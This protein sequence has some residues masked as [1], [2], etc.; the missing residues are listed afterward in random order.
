M[1]DPTALHE[2]R[3]LEAHAKRLQDV[4]LTSLFDGASSRFDDFS[5][6]AA[7]LFLDWSKNKI[8]REA[9]DGLFALARAAGVEARREAMFAGAP[10]NETEGRSVLHV[11]LRAPRGAGYAI[12][13]ADVSALIE[14]ERDRMQRFC[15]GVHKGAH[16]GFTDKPLTRV[17]NIGIGGSDLG[18][19]MAVEALRPY[20]IEG[21]RADFVSNIDGQHLAD[22][23]HDA[24][25][26]TTLFVIASKTFTTQETLTNARS[27]RDWFLQSGAGEADIAKHFVALSTNL[28]AV[29]AFGIDETNMFR[30]WDW[31]GGRYSLWSAIGLSIALQVGFS[32]FEKLLA[33]AHAMDEHFRS[34]PL[35]KNMPV[36]LAMAGVWNRNFQ[37]IAAHAVL[38]Y[39]QH[40]HRLP[41]Y[42]QQADM[43]SNGKRVRLDGGLSAC[44]TGPVLFG[45]PGTN[46][47]HAFY[48]LLHQGTD[49]VSADFIA[50]A[51]SARELGDHHEKLLANFLAQPEALMRGKSEKEAR[52][53]L[54]GAGLSD[55]EAARLASHKTFPGGR[56]SNAILM[57]R[58]TPETLGALIALYEHKIFVQGAVWGVNSFDQW[59]V[60]L[61]KALA[62]TILPEI[63]R[64]GESKPAPKGHDASTNGLIARVNAI[65]KKAGDAEH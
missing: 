31:V 10:I 50:A 35:E 57:E 42:L 62:K 52:A 41:A 40:L 18:P 3:A 21:R 23:L 15:E 54:E 5:L 32:N 13:G 59:G 39:D 6:E 48:Q 63:A 27:A 2:W 8:T 9:A 51:V 64:R 19:L 34:A 24:D 46:G 26:E 1:T 65:R 55:T 28:E 14:T 11:A 37:K 43:E 49:I 20:W 7:G 30:F 36:A 16:L 44:A 12:D 61:G 56:P 53:E 17:V 4:T 33:G 58:L 38:P 47:Q 60:E 22:T 29:K 25:P 45:E